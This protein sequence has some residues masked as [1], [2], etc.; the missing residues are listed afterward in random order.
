MEKLTIVFEMAEKLGFSLS[1]LTINEGI[2]L[3]N[4]IIDSIEQAIIRSDNK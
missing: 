3:K 1:G 4:E 2:S